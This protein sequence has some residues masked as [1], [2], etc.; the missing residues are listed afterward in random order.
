VDQIVSNFVGKFRRETLLGRQYLV[1]HVNL[2]VPGILAGS[3][4]PGLYPPEETGKDPGAWN[5]MPIVLYHPTDDK[6]MP[7]SARDPDILNKSG[8]GFVFRNQFDNLL[9]GEAW[10]EEDRTRLVSPHVHEAILNGTPLEISTGLFTRPDKVKGIYNGA[11]YHFIARDHK[12]DHLAVLPDKV[13]ACSLKD[14]CGI[15]NGNDQRTDPTIPTTNVIG[16]L[17][18]G[19]Y[20]LYSRTGGNL[21]TFE[22]YEA[23]AKHEKE[24]QYFSNRDKNQTPDQ[25]NDKMTTTNTNLPHGDNSMPLTAEQRSGIITYLTTNCDCWKG[26]DDPTILNGLSDDKLVTL[27]N[28][29]DVARQNS[30]VA[31]SLKEGF[32]DDKNVYKLNPQTNKFEATPKTNPAD[33]GL[34]DNVDFSQLQAGDVV[35]RVLNSQG[36]PKFKIVKKNPTQQTQTQNAT[37]KP[38][39]EQ[40]W[41]ASAP[42]RVQQVFTNAL[43][44]EAREKTA[45]VERLT[46]NIS[47]LAAK[48]AAV[49]VYNKMSAADLRPLA[50]SV[51]TNQQDQ[52]NN[53]G[54]NPHLV[55]FFGSGGIP[56]PTGNSGGQQTVNDRTDDFKEAPVY[57]DADMASPYLLKYL[58][59]K[60]SA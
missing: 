24:V 9:H 55:S 22:T 58:N 1:V 34:V 15:N 50:A 37:S 60:I 5:H 31:N 46:A 2:I 18:T 10:F 7:V 12:P 57:N 54:M 49:A 23:A 14:G 11:E 42:P 28:N 27:K 32:E 6:G 26:K 19:K 48:A 51:V 17:P 52:L 25:P 21:G 36:Q 8:M 35:E 56:V 13:G 39:T 45:L 4:G 29:S 30:M 3:A 59:K 16:R 41:F 43:E 38:Q 44:A 33:A 53:G 47:D 40:E 20:R